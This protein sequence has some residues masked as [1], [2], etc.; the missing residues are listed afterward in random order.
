MWIPVLVVFVVALGIGGKHLVNPPAAE[1][2]TASAVL[3]FASTL[4]GFVITYSPIASDF[5]TY[6]RPEVPRWV[7][8]ICDVVLD[9]DVP[10]SWK[11]FLYSYLGFNVPIVSSRRGG[12]TCD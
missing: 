4:A 2:A 9:I 1:P 5:T 12:E 8:D 6:Y 11:I 10:C 3:S 7:I